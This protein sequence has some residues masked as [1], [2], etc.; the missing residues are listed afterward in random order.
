MISISID[1]RMIKASGIGRYIDQVIS[2]LVNDDNFDVLCLGYDDIMNFKWSNKVKFIKL[3]SPIFSIS[4]QFE[5]VSKIPKCE[6][7]WSPQYN[8]PILPIKAKKRVV[9]IPDVFQLAHFNSLSLLTKIYVR[10]I[11]EFAILL[12]DSIITISEFSKKEILKLT[13]AKADQ[14][15]V[16]FCGADKKFA[17]VPSL[18]TSKQN[19]IL[20]VGNV[21]PHKNLK[22]AILAFKMISQKFPKYKF[23]I[24]GKKEGFTTGI[25]RIAQLIAGIEDKIVFTGYVDDQELKQ[26]YSNASIFFFPSLYEGFGIP[27]LEAMLFNLPILASNVA[28][29][30]EVG[31]DAIMYCNPE[32]V[33]DMANKLE[34]LIN[35]HFSFTKDSYQ[36]QIDKFD[37]S[38][39]A[40]EY[41]EIF[42]KLGAN[43]I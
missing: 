42:K 40:H 39:S 9:T 10:I 35:G 6:I 29:L 25:A 33:H 8:I 32:D 19:Y 41:I 26:Y 4:E 3:K 30:A 1:A 43:E 24:I 13:R 20:F 31:G 18:K 38:N 22:N 12:S 21:K 27:I 14:I 5:L 11:T 37:W 28:S 17:D 34:T 7:F 2:Y 23:Y 16:I 36:K 15:K